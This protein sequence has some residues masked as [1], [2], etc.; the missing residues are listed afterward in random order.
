MEKK[1]L[2]V[3]G[4][5]KSTL[6]QLM[7]QY[8]RISFRLEEMRLKHENRLNDIISEGEK[9]TELF[10]IHNFI[11]LFFKILFNDYADGFCKFMVVENFI[12]AVYSINF[13]AE[14][15][16]PFNFILVTIQKLNDDKTMFCNIDIFVIHDF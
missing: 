16:F 4:D 11:I 7:L 15:Y 3:T 5:G 12:F 9:Y 10:I 6:W 13:P 2:E 1:F 14:L 8:A